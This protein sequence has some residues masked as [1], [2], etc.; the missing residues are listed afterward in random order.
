MSEASF[1]TPAVLHLTLANKHGGERRPPPYWLMV[2]FM[3]PTMCHAIYGTESKLNINSS[4]HPTSPK[5]IAYDITYTFTYP[6]IPRTS[7][8]SK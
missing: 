5:T 4:L 3:A 8:C 1:D 7:F 6:V 2:P